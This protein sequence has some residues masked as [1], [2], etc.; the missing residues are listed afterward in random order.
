MNLICCVSN[1][2]LLLSTNDG[3]VYSSNENLPR[4]SSFIQSVAQKFTRTSF[5]KEIPCE[6]FESILIDDKQRVS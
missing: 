1:C 3:D 2:P 4:R 5:K 6:D